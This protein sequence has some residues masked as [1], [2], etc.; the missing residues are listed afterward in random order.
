MLGVLEAPEALIR[1]PMPARMSFDLAEVMGVSGELPMTITVTMVT[2]ELAQRLLDRNVGNRLLRVKRKDI[3][4]TAMEEGRFLFTGETII[5]D[6]DGVL[7]NGQHRCTGIV[8]SGVAEP[9]V[10]VEGIDPKAASVLDQGLQRNV[11]DILDIDGDPL[12]AGRAVD[13]ARLAKAVMQS[14]PDL[15]EYVQDN[16]RVAQLVRDQADELEFWTAWASA[17][18]SNAPRADAAAGRRIVSTVPLALFGLYLHRA[19]EP[20][21]SIDRFCQGIIDGVAQTE[22][23]SITFSNIRRKMVDKFPLIRGGGTQLPLTLGR[24]GWL[25]DLYSRWM[26]G[27]TIRRIHAPKVEYI[28]DLDGL[29]KP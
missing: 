21:E 19:G 18:S 5:I 23:D 14:S 16:P 24:M 7:R 11:R 6:W 2:P 22:D 26:S 25:V 4:R 15:V 9:C 13:M 28:R 20:V 27:E 17:L 10:I 12:P 3:L 1:T 8:E 29:P